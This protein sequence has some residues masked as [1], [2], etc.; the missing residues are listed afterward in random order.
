ML[1]SSM[2]VQTTLS[3]SIITHLV[4]DLLPPHLR[5]KAHPLLLRSHPIL[6][7]P[8]PA[9]NL[10]APYLGFGH[11]FM[12]SLPAFSPCLAGAPPHC[13][14][15][16]AQRLL[17]SRQKTSVPLCPHLPQV[18]GTCVGVRLFVDHKSIRSYSCAS[19]AERQPGPPIIGAQHTPGHDGQ[20]APAHPALLSEIKVAFSDCFRIESFFQVVM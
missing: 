17:P 5:Q 12:T 10:S 3:L 13:C 1:A 11:C 9:Q 18:M 2:T 7:T 4:G 19:V 20:H 8:A 6:T 15:S 14:L 16:R